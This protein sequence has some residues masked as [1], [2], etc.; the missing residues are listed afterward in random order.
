MTRWIALLRGVNVNG[1]SV[2]SAELAEL[3]RSLGFGAVKTVL[4]SGNV[5]FDS[6]A[7]AATVKPLIEKGLSDRFG[8]TAW[9]V[10]RTQ[11]ALA[12]AA[13]AYPFERDDDVH[14]PYL[15]FGSDSA[16]LAEMLAAIGDT[17]PAVERVAA[18]DGC[19]YWRVLKGSTV[20]TPVGK[21]IAKAKYKA[22]TTNRNLRTVEKLLVA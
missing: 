17:D 22:T 18:G 20:D 4:A 19:V 16:V 13:A 2:K 7:T 21:L 15:L 3:F 10:L 14:H 8:Y 1:I 12:E 11:A 9:I 5:A 6:D